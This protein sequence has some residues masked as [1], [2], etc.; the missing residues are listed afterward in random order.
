MSPLPPIPVGLSQR[1]RNLPILEPLLQ[2]PILVDGV[3]E[4]GGA[5]G[6]AYAGAL[7]AL[8]HSNIWF[9]RVAG[10]SAGS[11]IAAMIA[12]GFTAGEVQWLMSPTSDPP[13]IL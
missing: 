5:L 10:T 11:I 13:R 12:V 2:N 3:F 8:A 6:A 4:G 7:N 1:L 9:A